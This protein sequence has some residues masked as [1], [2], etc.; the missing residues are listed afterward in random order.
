LLQAQLAQERWRANNLVYA[1]D[2]ATLGWISAESPERH[3]RLRVMRADAVDFLVT[4]QPVG[5]QAR[6][7][8]GV[9]A[10]G[11]NGPDYS[12][13]FADRACWRR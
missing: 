7:R 1:R 13:G 10:V 3:Y 12:A 8:C 2:L 5:G 9:F 4:A 6:D 11:A